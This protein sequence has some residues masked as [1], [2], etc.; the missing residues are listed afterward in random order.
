MVERGEYGVNLLHAPDISDKRIVWQAP[1]YPIIADAIPDG[2]CDTRRM[3]HI[4][5]DLALVRDAMK[6]QKVSQGDLARAIGLPT[7][8]AVSNIFSGRRQVKVQEAQA[9]YRYLAITPKG[10]A[11]L[12]SLP[13]IGLTGAGN[14]REAIDVPLGFM[15]VP[16]TAAGPKAFGVQVSGDS[17]DRLIDDGGWIVVD[18]DQK[19]LQ[20]GKCYLIQNADHEVTVKCY[21]RGPA[22]FE[23]MSS[24]DEHKAFLVSDADFFVLGRVV[25]K[26]SPL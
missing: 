19:D 13:I 26:G 23:P 9:I 5:F 17:M 22:R 1:F 24:N 7:Q 11:P 20:H 10:D 15:S 4:A 2:L 16:A 12:R 8:S 21:Q 6:A 25:W 18:P 14:W 3:D